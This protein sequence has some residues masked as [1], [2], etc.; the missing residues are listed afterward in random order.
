MVLL[1]TTAEAARVDEA[2]SQLEAEEAAATSPTVGTAAT[3]AAAAASLL[4]KRVRVRGQ[5]IIDACA[6]YVYV[7]G[8][9]G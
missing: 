8:L 7:C 1:C 4:G 3:V 9:T 5:C 6:W 2:R